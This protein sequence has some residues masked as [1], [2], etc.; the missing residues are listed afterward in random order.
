MKGVCRVCGCTEERACEGGCYWV[1]SKKELCSAC[2]IRGDEE[3]EEK[4][5]IQL[6]E[7]KDRFELLRENMKS[8]G[9]EPPERSDED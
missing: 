6:S 3:L 7:K 8:Q 4:E 5:V 9:I 2:S 1:D